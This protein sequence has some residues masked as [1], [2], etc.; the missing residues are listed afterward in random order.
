MPYL[1]VSPD[2][3]AA[4]GDTEFNVAIAQVVGLPVAYDSSPPE[5]DSLVR[6]H[7]RKGELLKL[8]DIVRQH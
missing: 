2:E 4:V 6:V 1:A 8:L 3:S 5:L 7:L